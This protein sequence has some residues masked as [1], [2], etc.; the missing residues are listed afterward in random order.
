[1]IY[2]TVII[3]IYGKAKFNGWETRPSDAF[4]CT[5]FQAQI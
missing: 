1:M 5:V 3:D 2:S 4:Y